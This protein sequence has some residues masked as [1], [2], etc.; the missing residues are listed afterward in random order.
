MYNPTLGNFGTTAPKYAIGSKA[1]IHSG[2]PNSLVQAV[3]TPGKKK[4]CEIYS[5]MLCCLYIADNLLTRNMITASIYF[6][7]DCLQ[8][9]SILMA[10]KIIKGQNGVT[11]LIYFYFFFEFNTYFLK[12]NNQPLWCPVNLH[13]MMVFKPWTLIFYI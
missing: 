4:A 12:P 11:V 1:A 10:W 5:N 7:V 13:L 8:C 9:Y 2:P 3:D 6:L